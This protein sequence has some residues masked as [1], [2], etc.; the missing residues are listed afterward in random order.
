MLELII[1]LALSS[2]KK[3]G[4]RFMLT[5]MIAAKVGKMP[6]IVHNAELGIW[7]LLLECVGILC[8]DLQYI[9]A[10]HEISQLLARHLSCL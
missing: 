9:N 10:Q 7:H 6:A 2:S 4:Q 5:G 8:G 1:L 3:L